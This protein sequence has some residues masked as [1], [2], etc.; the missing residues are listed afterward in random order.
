MATTPLGCKL[1]LHHAWKWRSTEDG[2]R[3][4]RCSRCGKDHTDLDE[5]TFEGKRFGAGLAGFGGGG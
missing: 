2:S 3:Y 1:N 4:Q 5:G